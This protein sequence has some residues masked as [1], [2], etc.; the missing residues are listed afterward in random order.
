MIK[1]NNYLVIQG[2][3]INELN[4]SGN[5]LL[6]FAMIYGFSQDQNSE[7]TGSINYVCKWLNCTRPTAIKSL[8][9]LIDKGYV[10]RESQTINGVILNRYR[11]N[12][13]GS[14]E[15][16]QG[17]KKFDWGS[18]ETLLGGGKESLPNNTI[19][20]NTNNRNSNY[21]RHREIFVEKVLEFQDMLGSELSGFIE[22]WTETDMKGKMRVTD[23][24]YFDMKRRINTWMKNH[25]NFKFKKQNNDQQISKFEKNVQISKQVSNDIKQQINDGT[26]NNPFRIN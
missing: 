16:L 1:D 5:E 18:K 8:K 24:K 25:K 21:Y 26:F 3:M 10:L 2:W 12:A 7:F 22:Y 17:V 6:A 23:A 20:I 4:L 11:V 9:G 14:K 13:G 19:N 15:S